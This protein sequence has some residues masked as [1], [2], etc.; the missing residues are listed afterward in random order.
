MHSRLLPS[1]LQ[2]ETT[3]RCNLRC[4]TCLRSQQ[5]QGDMPFEL[6]KSIIDQYKLLK[7]TGRKIDL[8]GVGEPLL[9]T[10]LLPMIRYAKT[11]ETKVGWES[12]ALSSSLRSFLEK[13]TSL[14]TYSF[15]V[16]KTEGAG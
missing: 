6:F 4:K 7:I 10:E 11:N 9:N 12:M 3:T 1:S 8:T 14:M 2:I 16:G 5:A 15:Q 13:D